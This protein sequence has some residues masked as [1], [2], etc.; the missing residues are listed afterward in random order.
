MLNLVRMSPAEPISLLILA[1]DLNATSRH[2][3][4]KDNGGKWHCVDQDLLSSLMSSRSKKDI[5]KYES[6]VF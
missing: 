6:K 3:S 4:L 5:E 1:S 2:L